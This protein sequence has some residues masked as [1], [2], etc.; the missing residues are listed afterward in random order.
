MHWL[1]WFVCFATLFLIAWVGIRQRNESGK[2]NESNTPWWAI[3]LSIMAT[4]ASA[5]TFLSTPGLGYEKGLGFVQFYFGMPIALL[6]V[7]FGLAPLF[8]KSGVRTAYEWVERKFDLKLRL[9]TA[10]LFLLQRGMAAGITIY[11]PSIILTLV[12]GWP[13]WFNILI[14]G[15]ITLAYTAIGGDKAVTRTHVQQM[16]IIFTGIFI[17]FGLMMYYL[18]PFANYSDILKLTE[19]LG[20]L[21]SINTHFDPNDRYNLWSGLIGGTFLMLSYFGTDQSQVQRYLSGKSLKEIRIGLGFNALLKI[22]MQL[23]ILFTGVVLYA[24]YIFHPTPLSFDPQENQYFTRQEKIILTEKHQNL[25]TQ[26][27]QKAAAYLQNSDSLH[28]SQY[29]LADQ[30]WNNWEDSLHQMALNKGYQ[31]KVKSADF[32]FINFV[33]NYLPIGLIGLLLAVIFS[34]AMSSTSAELSALA[35]TAYNDFLYRNHTNATNVK[36]LPW[37]TLF[38]GILAILF[39]LAASMFES[40]VEAVNILGSLFY[41]TVLGVFLAGLFS[42]HAQRTWVLIGAISA[43]LLIFILF[44]WGEALGLNLA[45]LWYN[46]LACVWICLFALFGKVFRKQAAGVS[47]E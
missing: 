13:L 34:A 43:Q 17:A 8:H 24:F 9:F 46:L 28:L 26:R 35:T 21:K 42:G 20:K 7:A 19:V 12:L 15:G 16:A 4:Q 11:A 40:L 33:L 25:H 47:K 45:F 29:L 14:I 41:G 27:H 22:P 31:P 36:K 38:W 10:F 3:G 37:I 5:I 18:K 6:F 44:F 30:R 2:L 23:G 32:V 39:A 1:D